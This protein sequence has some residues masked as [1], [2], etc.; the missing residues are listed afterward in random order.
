MPGALAEELSANR[1]NNALASCSASRVGVEQVQA[2]RAEAKE[3]CFF[4][5][6]HEVHL[7][8]ANMFSLEPTVV[9]AQ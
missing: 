2:E 5:I 8:S 7:L 4:E 3:E 9:R 1:A 6:R